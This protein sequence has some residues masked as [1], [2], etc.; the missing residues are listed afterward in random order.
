M[1]CLRFV[2]SKL[3]DCV[4]AIMISVESRRRALIKFIVPNS[5]YVNQQAIL[6]RGLLFFLLFSRTFASVLICA[7]SERSFECSGGFEA[8]QTHFS[9]AV[10]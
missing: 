7:F 1:F 10:Q 2:A 9:S 3:S 4:L 6:I 8:Q 5:I